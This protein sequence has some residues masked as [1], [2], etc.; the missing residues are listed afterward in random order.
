MLLESGTPG[1]IAIVDGDACALLLHHDVR[2]VQ[3]VA[4]GHLHG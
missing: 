4:C 1:F 3:L 2:F